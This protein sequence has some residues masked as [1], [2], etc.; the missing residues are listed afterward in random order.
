MMITSPFIFIIFILIIILIC[1][2]LIVFQPKSK[3]IP[4]PSQIPSDFFNTNDNW[5]ETSSSNSI[6]SGNTISGSSICK[7][8]I[9]QNSFNLDKTPEIN[10]IF[11]DVYKGLAHPLGLPNTIDCLEQNEIMA[12]QGFHKCTSNIPNQCI[13]NFGNFIKKN[14]GISYVVDCSENIKLCTGNIVNISF[15]FV[16]NNED[17]L[18]INTKFLEVENIF[19]NNNEYDE[20]KK[21]N[22]Y[23]F[24]EGIFS[25]STS[26]K[27][28]EY[29]PVFSNKIYKANSYRQQFKINRYSYSNDKKIFIENITG[30]YMSIIYKPI[31]AYLTTRII[32]DQY[33][34]FLK[35]KNNVKIEDTIQ[36]LSI[37]SLNL[38]NS[39]I[40][41][42]NK[43]ING[44]IKQLSKGST[45][46]GISQKNF[47][48]INDYFPEYNKVNSNETIIETIWENNS[49]SI[50][51]D[52]ISNIDPSGKTIISN[53]GNTQI[54]TNI[55]DFNYDNYPDK[56]FTSL[57]EGYSNEIADFYYIGV[58]AKNNSN[59]TIIQNNK[60]NSIELN[61]RE[62]IDI[63]FNID[64]KKPISNNF[65]FGDIIKDNQVLWEVKNWR[66]DIY[67]FSPQYFTSGGLS[68]ASSLQIKENKKIYIKPKIGIVNNI[69]T[70]KINYDYKE[71]PIGNY[72]I[73]LNSENTENLTIPSDNTQI[74]QILIVF[75]KNIDSNNSIITDIQIIK[76]GENYKTEN[77]NIKGT[78][79]DPKAINNINNLNLQV[80]DQEIRYV[81]IPQ[82]KDGSIFDPN[83]D[84]NDEEKNGGLFL[85][86]SDV[87]VNSDGSLK[88]NKNPFK[89]PSI[90]G[91]FGY[92]IGD[93]IKIDQVDQYNNSLLPNILKTDLSTFEILSIQKPNNG[94]SS[95][96]SYNLKRNI[97]ISKG[98][99]LQY[100]DILYNFWEDNPT[101]NE[102]SSS[103]PQIAFIGNELNNL[104]N[105]I[106]N[107]TL[108]QYLDF[109]K[110]SN[111]SI[112]TI[113]F[114]E[115][116]YIGKNINEKPPNI[117]IK[118]DNKIVL[119]R[120]IPYSKFSPPKYKKNDKNIPTD[121]SNK[122][123]YNDN[124]TQFVPYGI[125]NIYNNISNINK[126]PS[127]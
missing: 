35:T 105:I 42:N 116:N 117:T 112:K 126:L 83:K 29:L 21:L 55:Y 87:S 84:R 39:I 94:I 79:L 93:E 3:K 102:Y 122:I 31:N 48:Q 92:E 71:F 49:S 110:I 115:L 82:K 44:N 75:S 15:N 68:I 20:L 67:E 34:F 46:Y 120:F 23:Y 56:I 111:D 12:Y 19:I 8:Y 63:N 18:D 45:I 69:N 40:T 33:E 77:F 108:E 47:F 123:F 25:S 43:F 22:N 54:T 57:N 59:N 65:N 127:I 114:R 36:W 58:S 5:G 14:E 30:P 74:S 100:D 11:N 97:G 95:P 50:N 119:G 106:T 2:L 37:P 124:Y 88:L 121:K 89:V 103:P 125:K 91:G 32:N 9:Y 73:D 7:V 101:A 27:K 85:F 38:N 62:N 90:Q 81:A 70:K 107:G 104:K 24:K 64:I 1:I 61:I 52:F 17:I 16:F 66:D 78:A 96:S 60:I 28:G 113:Q 4:S 53:K 10:E 118:E 72:I 86:D 76:G 109:I 6:I 41:K 99:P 26:I 13:D 98:F 51:I 80:V